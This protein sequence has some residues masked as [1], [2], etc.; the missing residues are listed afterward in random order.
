MWTNHTVVI[1]DFKLEELR[2]VDFDL[3]LNLDFYLGDFE[4]IDTPV[5]DN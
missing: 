5:S 2:L 3:D 4:L 1:R